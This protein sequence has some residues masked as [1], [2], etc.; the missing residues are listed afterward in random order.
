MAN[1]PR[2]TSE[3]MAEIFSI[4]LRLVAERGFEATTMDSVAETAHTSKA[5]LYRQWGDKVGLVV[6]ALSCVKPERGELP[7]TGTLRGDLHELLTQDFDAFAGSG[8]LMSA[9][10]HAAAGNSDLRAALRERFVADRDHGLRALIDR[11]VAR[12]EV[13][14][15]APGIRHASVVLL[16]PVVLHDVVGEDPLDLSTLLDYL[17]HVFLASLGIAPDQTQES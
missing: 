15:D 8:L 4:T 2:L 3:R 7:D 1:S 16:A 6:E 12:G 13:S 9:I 11:A 5:T 10:V 17:D 14:A